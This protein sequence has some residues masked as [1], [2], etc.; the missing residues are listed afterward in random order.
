MSEIRVRRA[1]CGDAAALVRVLWSVEWLSRFREP[2]EQA[3]R[4]QMEALLDRCLADDS[5]SVYVAE[6]GTEV[7]GYGVVHWLPYP[8]LLG[9]EG[10]VSDLFIHA[11]ARGRGA[12]S[13]LLAEI[14]EEAGNRGCCRLSLLNSREREAYHRGFYRGA[15]WEERE[16]MVNFVLR[17]P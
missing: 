15:G 3:C 2:G 7:V 5:H 6:L 10:F 4:R 17:L 13:A 12:G 14:K 8:V 11:E 9:V 16:T 1:A